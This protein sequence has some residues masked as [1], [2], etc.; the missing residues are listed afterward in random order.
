MTRH[1]T[2]QT[3]PC[4]L[5]T[6]G[7]KEGGGVRVPEAETHEAASSRTPLVS[8]VGPGARGQDTQGRKAATSGG[9]PP[10]SGRLASGARTPSVHRLRPPQPLCPQTPPA[11]PPPPEPGPRARWTTPARHPLTALLCRS[12]LGASSSSPLAPSQ[13][14]CRHLL[15]FSSQVSSGTRFPRQLAPFGLSLVR[16]KVH[17]RTVPF[18]PF[19]LSHPVNLAFTACEVFQSLQRSPC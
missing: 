13:E 16:S 9:Q 2:R 4:E 14:Q 19:A 15:F 6:R 10:I 17:R 1:R 18:C 7:E 5:R 11:S 12:P 8:S 3:P